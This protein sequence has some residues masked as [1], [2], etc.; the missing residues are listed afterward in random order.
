MKRIL[1]AILAIACVEAIAQQPAP[2]FAPSNLS[3]GGIRGAAASC[4]ACHGTNGRVTP[5]SAVAGLAGR[6]EGELA[7]M[8]AQFKSGERPATVMHQ[9][10]KGYSD[11]EI[12]AIARHFS[13]LPR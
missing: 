7:Q 4:A 10:A 6:P 8:M 11:A 1:A 9:I 13:R 12:G 3:E 2:S 5:D